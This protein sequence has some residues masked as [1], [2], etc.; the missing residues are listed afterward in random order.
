MTPEQVF[1]AWRSDFEDRSRSVACQWSQLTE[2]LGTLVLHNSRGAHG[3]VVLARL[4]D[5]EAIVSDLRLALRGCEEEVAPRLSQSERLRHQ[6][7]STTLWSHLKPEIAFQKGTK[8]DHFIHVDRDLINQTIERYMRSPWLANDVLEWMMVNASVYH[9]VVSFGESIK[10]NVKGVSEA[11]RAVDIG[12]R[13]RRMAL[14][15]AGVFG[16][17][18]AFVVA[19][20]AAAVLAPNYITDRVVLWIPPVAIGCLTVYTAVR[21]TLLFR[22][23]H[24]KQRI[25][26]AM[27]QWSAMCM[28]YRS[29]ERPVASLARVTEELRRAAARGAIWSQSTFALLKFATARGIQ[30]WNV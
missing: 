20:I 19:P 11:L 3:R 27:A 18:S 30:A 10:A 2:A 26:K 12:G 1:E 17:L 25:G 29:L 7:L 9:K 28:A 14:R 4:N 21:M 22:R 8:S 24:E 5:L 23:R 6:A 13:V 16:E 15:T